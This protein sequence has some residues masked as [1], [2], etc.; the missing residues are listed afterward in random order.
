MKKKTLRNKKMK[1]CDADLNLSDD[2]MNTIQREFSFTSKDLQRLNLIFRVKT[3]IRL[4]FERLKNLRQ[5]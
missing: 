5:I 1:S 3:L 2:E 4:S